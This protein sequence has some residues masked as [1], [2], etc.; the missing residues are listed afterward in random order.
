[1]S[2]IARVRFS[3]KLAPATILRAACVAAKP[4]DAPVKPPPRLHVDADLAGGRALDL[5]V[6][7]AHHLATV[8]RLGAGAAVAV[9]NGRDGE[10]LARIAEAGRGRCRLLVQ[11]Q[12]RAQAAGADLWLAFAPIKRARLDFLVEKATEL[13]VS[14]LLPVITRHTVAE[15]VTL[16]RLRAIAIA[17]AEQ[18]ERLTLPALHPPQALE[19]LLAQWPMDRR[20][21]LC[22][23]SGTAPPIAAALAGLAPGAAAVLTGP[24]GGFAESE[25]DD[26]G[27]FP[28]VCSPRWPWPRR[29]L[30]T[31][32]PGAADRPPR[33][34]IGLLR[35]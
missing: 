4:A 34:P 20:L 18:S 3:A 21:I 15:R 25:L 1:M 23:E 31:G 29:C 35:G 2:V 28:F 5:A 19:R 17:A 6:P 14:A 13:G 7:Q 9:F 26:L 8:L 27:K 32:R 33:R 11:E 22:D 10:W 12:L 30:A 16:T 24:E